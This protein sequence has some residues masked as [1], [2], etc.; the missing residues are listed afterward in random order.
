MVRFGKWTILT[1]FIVEVSGPIAYAQ[2]GTSAITGNITDAS[3]AVIAEVAVKIVNEES[4]A[5]ILTKSNESGVYR[6]ASLPPG[7]YR[8]EAETP[9]FETLVRRGLVLAVSQVLAVDLQLELGKGRETVNVEAATPLAETQSSSTGQL[10]NRKMVAG[11]PMPNRAA[12]ALAA[13]A[14]G[15]VMIDSGTGAE[16]YPLFSVAGGRAR[17][18]NF[19]LDGG[20][21]TN[22]VGL[23]RPQ[24]MTSLPMDA[25]QEFRVI[26]NNYAAEYGHSTGGVITLSTRS[27]TNEFH[28]SAFDYIRNE[29]LDARNFFAARK[30]PLRQRQ[31]G[32]AFG[33]PIRRDRTHFFLSWE[34]TRQVSSETLLQTVPSLRQRSGDFSGLRDAAGKPIVI[35]D[36]AT[37]VGRK[38]MPFPGNIIPQNRFDPVAGAALSYWPLPNRPGTATGANNFVGNN[39][40]HLHRDIIVAKLDHQLRPSDQ[41]TARYYI[42]DSSIDNRGSFGIPESDPNANTQDAR[43]Q[44]IMGGHT[45]IFRPSL[46]NELTV[47]FLQRKFIDQRYGMDRN[48]AGALG[49]RGVSA[50]AFPIFTLPG[51]ASLGNSV[52]RLQTPIRD[53]QI[54]DA[55]SWNRGKHA[56]KVGVEH[57][58]GFNNEIRDRS[59]SGNFV[60]TPLITGNPGTSGTGDSE[61]SFLLGEVNSA[62]VLASDL[63]PSR[64]A[65]WA[66][67]IQDDWRVTDRLT[68]NYGLRW[69]TELPRRVDGDRMNSFDPVALNPV[70]GTPGVVT[71]AGRNGVPRQA[72]NTK[73]KNFG[74][75]FGFAY[76]LGERTVL[77]GGAGVFYGPTISNSV[78]DTA[79]TGFST[80][81]SLVVPQADLLSALRLRDG[82][83]AIQRPPLDARFGAVP[84]GVRPKTAV[85][86][87]E[88]NRPTPV[89]YQYN[90]NVQREL[91]QHLVLETGYLANVSHHLTANDLSI[92][93]LAPE[94][95]GPG[96]T[97]P[98][99]PFPQFS[100]VFLI[101]PAVGNSTYHAGYAK[102]EKRFSSGF[103]FL[104]HY[105]F[106]KFLDD[107]ASS[108][109]FG[110]TLSYMDAYKR[111]LD[112]GRSGS[113]VPHRF[114]ASGLYEV[115]PFQSSRLL[116]AVAGGWNIGLMATLESG[117][118]FSVVTLANTTNAFPAGPLRPDLIANPD[119]SSDQRSLFHWFDTGAFQ[120]PKGFR[121]GNSPRNGLRGA[122]LNTID[123]TTAKQFRITERYRADLRAEFYNL[124]N[125]ANFEVP[126]HTLGSAD[127]GVV[128]SARPAR[129]V[130]LGLRLSF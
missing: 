32:G 54:L 118:P 68:L 6:V 79:A 47:S 78:G 92:N 126:G 15:V 94:L 111:R 91:S 72:F 97:Q 83:P 58:R 117:P 17:N 80:S 60:I 120:S 26:S 5:S 33:G 107:V 12:T 71:F 105:T 18:Q 122:P 112:K 119:L 55:L 61:A 41:L 57:R 31:L 74:P 87:F 62:S 52:S 70:S 113:D 48:L 69:E 45:H 123:L 8:I 23:T 73:W 82:F 37:T 95:M 51:Y 130:Q 115:R 44:S 43:I 116:D 56:F 114:I 30:P 66:W 39:D 85:G 34:Q 102:A 121:F 77:R 124:L 90:F 14:P 104:A 75:R 128:S 108:V 88:R 20:N 27:G 100:N 35:F 125:H 50:A 65:Y 99:R 10:V 22:A 46:L 109:E 67:F 59:S 42:N 110:D 3:Q 84:K 86:F 96:D 24:Q 53:T 19:T 129:T 7:Q 63:I 16:N 76:R 29:A 28:G 40:S 21:V 13:L 101:N 64:A 103:S 36:P 38:R 127:F 1:L 9:G 98:L 93:Q 2:T 81:A 106:S 11:L 89:S 4:G 25:M 49:L